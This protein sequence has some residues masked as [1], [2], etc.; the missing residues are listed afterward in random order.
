MPCFDKKLEAS[1]AELTDAAWDGPAADG[2]KGVRDVDCVIT[3]KEVLMLAASRGID[4]FSLL[5]TPQSRTASALPLAQPAFPDPV[6]DAFLFPT[7]AGRPRGT[8]TQRQPSPAAGSSGGNLHFILQSVLAQNPGA[9]LQTVRGRNIDVVEYTITAPGGGAADKLLFRAARYYGFRNIQNLVRRLKPPRPSR[10]PGGRP[11]GGV[12]RRAGTAAGGA[13]AGAG[14]LDYAYVEVMACPGGCTNGGGQIKV[15]DE[16][17][18]ARRGGG[19][20]GVQNESRG[21]AAKLGSAEQKAWLAEIDEAYFSAENDSDSDGD[22]DAM[23]VD[24]VDGASEVLVDGINPAY[25]RETL[26]HWAR[27]T[28]IDLAKL[29]YTT[30]REVVSDVGKTANGQKAG[31]VEHVVQIASKIGGG[32]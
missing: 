27:L 18:V 10:L 24:G 25:V 22:G 8:Q 17:V 5:P 11:V 29:V 16:V 20:T 14:G 30:Y 4:F 6:L 19:D 1:R 21:A 15:D 3:S 32:W 9:T 7:R 23:S 28:G 26:A 12:A 31:S 2:Q 13:G